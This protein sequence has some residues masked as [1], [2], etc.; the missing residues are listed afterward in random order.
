ADAEDG[1][2]PAML[3]VDL[4]DFKHVND[5][6]GHAA[7]DQLLVLL[8]DRLRDATAEASTVA[9]LG[10]DE[11]AALV[12]GVRADADVTAIANRVTAALQSPFMVRGR[13]VR[14]AASLGIAI[15]HATDSADDLLRNADLAL[16]RAKALGKGR[17]AR[18]TPE[19]L[20]AAVERLELESELHSALHQRQFVLHY[21]PIV[22]LATRA[23]TGVEA[24]VRWQHPERGT[25]S[26]DTFIPLAESTGLV[27]PLGRWVLA[28][29]CRTVAGWNA[30]RCSARLL[31]VSVNVSG[32]QL[33]HAGF[34]EDV[35]AA[36]HAS[37]L[38]ASQLVL[39]VTESMLL[40]DVDAAVRRLQA[41][42]ALGVRVALDDFGTG[43]S[44]LAYL[45]R[46]PVDVLKIDRAFITHIAGCGREAAFA[47]AV[48]TFANTLGMC[49]VA[50]GVET[51]MQ[52]DALC[53]LECGFGQGFHYGRPLSADAIYAT[54][55][56][57][58]TTHRP[59]NESSSPATAEQAPTKTILVV[60]NEASIRR[61]A[62]RILEAAGYAVVDVP[63]GDE[64]LR[65]LERHRNLVDLVLTEVHTPALSGSSLV[66]L[67]H[68]ATAAERLMPPV[69]LM[70]GGAR[71]QS[72]P[73]EP[74]MEP[75]A[76]ISKPFTATELLG[77][78]GRALGNALAA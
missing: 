11:F 35:A 16:Y 23:I 14:V 65:Y 62:R 28:E 78:V 6:L 42:R 9:R 67:L 25:V 36:L 60:D 76:R 77:S 4:D 17:I 31:T 26:P 1:R 38:P 22:D 18:F 72:K 21:Q 52:H 48:I 53:A 46:L 59:S 20:T 15:A 56:A 24:L 40:E 66:E 10:G 47:R 29:A 12:D 3:L 8:A 44:S 58:W 71:S 73:G 37:G 55:S 30:A 2:R 50:E 33:Q 69:L 32:R 13:E 68:G 5:S 27:V 75:V 70:S 64:A 63:D 57:S 49:T 41:L 43:Y 61:L 51:E 19:L 54:L 45:Q 74:S 34:L 39:E 7:G